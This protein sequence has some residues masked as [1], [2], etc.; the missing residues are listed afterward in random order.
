MVDVERF[1]FFEACSEG[2]LVV[3][4]HTV[5]PPMVSMS[6]VRSRALGGLPCIQSLHVLV[7]CLTVFMLVCLLH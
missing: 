5:M 2:P 1:D 4:V 6:C 3:P 7:E